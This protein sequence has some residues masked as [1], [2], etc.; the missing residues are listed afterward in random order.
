MRLSL[1]TRPS[2]TQWQK[3]Q[4]LAARITTSWTEGGKQEEKYLVYFKT[5]QEAMKALAD[6]N[7]NLFDLASSEITFYNLYERW[8]KVK[9]KNKPVS[10]GYTSAYKKFVPLYDTPFHEIRKRHIQSVIDSLNLYD[11]VQICY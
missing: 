4:T 10:A 2:K 5:R 8:C 11:D 3:T 7:E 6:Y 9:Y 1:P